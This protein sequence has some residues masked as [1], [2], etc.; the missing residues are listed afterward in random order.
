MAAASGPQGGLPA[1][2]AAVG[3]LLV[4]GL[5]FAK[6]KTLQAAAFVDDQR[7]E[8]SCRR[9]ER[10]HAAQFA[11]ERRAGRSAPAVEPPPAGGTLQPPVRQVHLPFGDDDPD[12]AATPCIASS[13]CRLGCATIAE[14]MANAR[15]GALR[16]VSAG[17]S[18]SAGTVRSEP[19]YHQPQGLAA[20]SE[21]PSDTAVAE[22][23]GETLSLRCASC[24]ARFVCQT[25]KD[26]LDHC[27]SYTVLLSEQ[28]M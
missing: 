17:T 2:G 16:T 25:V 3:G 23:F 15:S 6:E 5:S 7:A 18:S 10:E 20:N 22:A 28:C 12:E 19:T 9:L 26:R 4:S 14:H 21:E 24:V 1:A 8:S 11:A 27:C 13:R